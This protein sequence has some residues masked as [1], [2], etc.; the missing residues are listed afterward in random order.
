VRNILNL[1]RIFF[2]FIFTSIQ[3]KIHHFFILGQDADLKL[4]HYNLLNRVERSAYL[5]KG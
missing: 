4:Q 1:P 3:W 5:T 2:K